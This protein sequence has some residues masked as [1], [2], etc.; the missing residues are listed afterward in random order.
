MFEER[1]DPTAVEYLTDFLPS[2][3]NIATTDFLT[4]L[5][6]FSRESCTRLSDEETEQVEKYIEN[7]QLLEAEQ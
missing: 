2:D 4:F 7:Q 3:T 1:H 5:G 6:A